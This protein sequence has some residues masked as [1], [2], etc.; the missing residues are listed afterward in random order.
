M[1]CLNCHHDIPDTAKICAHCEAPVMEEP[2]EEEMEAARALLRAR[3]DDQTWR[4][5]LEEK[6]RALAVEPTLAGMIE[7]V[8]IK[9]E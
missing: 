4:R 9:D 7:I 5:D 3:L 1:R 2:T 6:R 8:V